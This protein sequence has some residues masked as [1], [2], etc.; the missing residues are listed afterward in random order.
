MKITKIEQDGNVFKVTREPR[1]VGR[2]FG[3]KQRIDEYKDTG[4][5]YNFGGGRV[6]VN[7]EGVYLGN[8]FGYGV[9]TREAIDYWR[10]KF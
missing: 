9:N 5:I 1:F 6:Y 3:I 7:K 4:R 2:M 10:S 8:Q